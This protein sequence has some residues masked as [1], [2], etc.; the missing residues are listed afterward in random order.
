MYPYGGELTALGL[1]YE[2]GMRETI[3]H[4]TGH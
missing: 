4:K 2:T 3:L 1:G